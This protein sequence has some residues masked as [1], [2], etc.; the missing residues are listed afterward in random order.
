MQNNPVGGFN[1]IQVVFNDDNRIALFLQGLND[2]ELTYEIESA[3]LAM[4]SFQV[5]NAPRPAP[6]SQTESLAPGALVDT[7]A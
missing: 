6:Q 1:D 2:S 4:G 5:F 3:G 7:K